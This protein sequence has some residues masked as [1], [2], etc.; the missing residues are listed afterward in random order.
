MIDISETPRNLKKK[1]YMSIAE[2]H[3][4]HHNTLNTLVVLQK[5]SD[6]NFDFIYANLIRKEKN[7]LKVH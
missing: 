5:T 6:H 2:M 4:M 7:S 3:Y 1:E